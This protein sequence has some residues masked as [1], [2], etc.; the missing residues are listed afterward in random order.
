MT[1]VK[2][3]TSQ[4]KYQTFYDRLQAET[5]VERNKLLSSPIIQDAL[6]GNIT[7]TQYQAFLTQ[8]Y[9]HVKHTLPLLMS[10]GGRLGG[11]YEWLREAVAEYIEEETGHQEWILSDI[12]ATG[13]DAEAVRHGRPHPDTEVMVAYAYHCIDRQNPIMFFGMVHVLE[14]TSVTTATQAGEIIQRTL[15]LPNQAFSYLYSHGSLDQE[16]IRFFENL[17]VR[18]SDEN[19]QAD[20]IHA[21]KMF[22]ELYGRVFRSLPREV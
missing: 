11:E 10:C 1:A 18:V 7:L 6:Q 14:G 19:D 17:M 4:P 13:A 12:A 2:E 3:L 22:Y 20:I 9:H 8:A 16:H 5:V 21:S 15:G